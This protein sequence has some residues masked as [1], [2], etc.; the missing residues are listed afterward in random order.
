MQT[1]V[2]RGKVVEVIDYSP[3]PHQTELD[4][5][6]LR[7]AV[8]Q[9]G[10]QFFVPVD[11]RRSGKSSGLVNSLI[12]ICTTVKP[13]GQAYYFYPQQKKIREHIWDNPELLPKYLPRSMVKKKD[14]QRMVL[15]FKG[16]WQLIFDG[17]DE[18][19]DKHRGG[20]GRVYVVDEYDDQQERIFTEIIR[21]I[22]EFNG[23]IA[24]LSGT[25]RGVKQLHNAYVAGQDPERPQWW[26][27][28][29]PATLSRRFDG[30]RLLTDEQL[31]LIKKDYIASGVGGAFE[32]EMMCAFNQDANQ[33]FRRIEDVVKDDVGKLLEPKDPEEGHYYRIGCDPAITSDYWVNSVLDLH[34][35]HEVAIERFQPNDTALGEAR[36]E[37]LCRKYGMAEIVIDEAGIGRPIADHLRDRGL[38]IFPVQTGTNKQRL[39]TELSLKIDALTIRFLP[40]QVAMGEMRD[41]AFNRLPSGTYQFGAPSGKHDDTV[42]ARAL[43]AWELP[44]K[45]PA[46]DRSFWG[47][48]PVSKT[49]DYYK[50]HNTYFGATRKRD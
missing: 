45:L 24:V 35:H 7:R 18:N 25:P 46:R 16:G 48:E 30:S 43:T 23:G 50:E 32:Q 31:E 3:Y 27:R 33:V 44:E 38:P 6:L 9:E 26:S 2:I 4:D 17:T 36:T 13:A 29:L 49:E 37:A 5:L 47:E 12:K 14:D 21:P 8:S 10:P 40:D 20:N 42:I 11:H 41:F 39:I 34:S 28:L 1:A 19:P 22:V 15:Y